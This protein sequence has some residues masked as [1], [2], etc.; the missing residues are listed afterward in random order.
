MTDPTE[1]TS[2]ADPNPWCNDQPKDSSQYLAVVDLTYA[3]NKEAQNCRY[4]WISHF[5]SA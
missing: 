3:W 2:S 5:V 1:Q 4:A